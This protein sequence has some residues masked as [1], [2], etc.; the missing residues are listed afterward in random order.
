L[1]YESLR[2]FADLAV[3]AE[4]EEEVGSSDYAITVGIVIPTVL[5]ASV[6]SEDIQNVRCG[7]QAIAVDVSRTRGVVLRLVETL[8]EVLIWDADRS[9]DGLADRSVKV[10]AVCRSSVE[11]GSD[12]VAPENRLGGYLFG[13]QP[14]SG[15][16][17][18]EE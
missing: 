18:D 5:Q 12:G 13:E 10:E 6:V 2:S 11:A 3:I 8:R 9:S 16:Q 1:K 15:E 4:D 7:D 17:H 14:A